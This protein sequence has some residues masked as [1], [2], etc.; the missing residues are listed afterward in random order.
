MWWDKV[1]AYPEW[2]GE[3]W[4]NANLSGNP[5]VVRNDAKIEFNWG[6]GTIRCASS[7]MRGSATRG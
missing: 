3:Y 6:T 7:T 1:S 4:P 5:L 2:K